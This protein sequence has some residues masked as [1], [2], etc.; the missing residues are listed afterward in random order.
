MKF[1]IFQESHI[2][3]RKSNQ[4]RLAHCHTRSALPNPARTQAG[5]SGD[6]LAR[7]IRQ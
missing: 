4:D 1:S 5:D 2:G 7:I 3:K 6:N